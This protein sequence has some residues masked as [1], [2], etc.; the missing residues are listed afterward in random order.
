MGKGILYGLLAGV[1]W[2]I[3]F[4]APLMTHATGLHLAFGRFIFFGF[5]SLFYWPEVKKIWHS[6]SVSEKWQ[7]FF[8]SASG[9]WLFTLLFFTGITFA[10]TMW[11]SLIAGC[12]PLTI[13]LADK[14]VRPLSFLFIACGMFS[15]SYQHFYAVQTSLFSRLWGIF[16]LL[17]CLALWTAFAVFNARFLRARPHISSR[18]FASMMGLSSFFSLSLLLLFSLP[19]FVFQRE[20]F[21]SPR[22]IFLSALLGIGSSWL[23]NLLWNNCSRLVPLGVAGLLIVSETFFGLLYNFFWMERFPTFYETMALFCFFTGL[24]IGLRR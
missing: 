11:A 23:A 15:L 20:L 1:L 4:V 6:L 2:G 12:L 18:H 17:I 5:I 10:G 14:R 13:A 21:L 24:L 7:C 9:F 8:L 3:P 16:L 22:F 19:F